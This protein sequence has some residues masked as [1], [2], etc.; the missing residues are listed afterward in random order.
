MR[1]PG[2][3][4]DALLAGRHA[5]PF[6]LLGLHRGPDGVFARALVPG[7]EALEAFTLA[8]ESLGELER[9]DDRGLFEGAVAGDP[10]P[11]RY[12]ATGSDGAEWTVTDPYS[13]GPVLGPVDDLLSTLR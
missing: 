1:P 10:Q 8:G 6:S 5:D 12:R 13:F 2:S 4:I 7:A 9:V 11:V 3:A